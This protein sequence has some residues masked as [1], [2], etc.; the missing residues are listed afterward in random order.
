[1]SDVPPDEED[2]S[3]LKPPSKVRVIDRTRALQNLPANPIGA[4]V[5]NKLGGVS[6]PRD[7]LGRTAAENFLKPSIA[8]EQLAKAAKTSSM[9]GDAARAA[10]PASEALRV[11]QE[12]QRERANLIEPPLDLVGQTA[13]SSTLNAIGS[14]AVLAFRAIHGAQ[15]QLK[16]VMQELAPIGA[17]F[18]ELQSSAAEY[19]RRVQELPARM[20]KNLAALAQA[21][22]FL[23]LGMSLSDV[24]DFDEDLRE[25]SA[26]DINAEMAAYFSGESERI[27]QGLI[28]RHPNRAA[29]IQE[30]FAA[31]RHGDLYSL[32]IQGFLS[33]ADGICFDK[34]DKQLFNKAGPSSKIKTL[35]PDT[36]QQVY[37]ELLGSKFP[38]NEPRK[39]RNRTGTNFN[40]HAIA[41]GESVDYNSEINSLKA[42]SFLN[43]VSHAF[44][45]V[46][47]DQDK[48]S[49]SED[50]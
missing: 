40:R 17:A 20:R 27:E 35:D 11:L 9:I 30:A 16:S 26:V 46:R 21:G 47:E 33:Q 8:M 44:D 45:L 48:I 28:E 39:T 12:Q 34:S 19:I 1:M 36:L 29:L 6:P 14:V 24:L 41:H 50:P 38:L 3:G 42:M 13:L 2:A 25:G 10:F 31:H 32:S 23:D 22:W 15:L 43:F 4:S 37:M 5:S 7:L 49:A 18:R